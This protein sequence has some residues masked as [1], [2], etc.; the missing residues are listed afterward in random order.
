[1]GGEGKVDS[2]RITGS[3][4]IPRAAPRDMYPYTYPLYMY[5]DWVSVADC[6]GYSLEYFSGG[7][8]NIK[9]KLHSLSYLHGII[10]GS[11]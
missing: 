9:L 10:G 6:L 5:M 1:M 2:E 3:R 7:F 8:Q 11:D 4:T